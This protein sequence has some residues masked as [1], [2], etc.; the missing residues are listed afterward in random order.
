MAESKTQD[1]IVSGSFYFPYDALIA[2]RGEAGQL[3][4]RGWVYEAVTEK[5][6]VLV[7]FDE[8]AVSV[9]E[10]ARVC[11]ISIVI[12]K[13]SENRNAKVIRSEIAF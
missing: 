8:V 6:V 7:L 2:S 12:L 5:M 4:S 1:E 3:I 11:T 10:S 9:S 13:R